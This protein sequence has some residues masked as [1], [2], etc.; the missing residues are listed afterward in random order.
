MLDRRMNFIKLYKDILPYCDCDQEYYLQMIEG[1]KKQY[2][3][4]LIRSAVTQAREEMKKR[5]SG[6]SYIS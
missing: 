6:N 5:E 4:E 3:E 2:M 1:L